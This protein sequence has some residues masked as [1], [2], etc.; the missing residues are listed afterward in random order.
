MADVAT[1][2]LRAEDLGK[3]RV[4]TRSRILLLVEAAI[5]AHVGVLIVAG[6]YYA[7]F[8]TTWFMHNWWHSLVPNGAIR[9]N[10]RDVGEGVLGA[11]LAKAVLWDHFTKSHQKS[12]RIFDWLHEK[13]HIPTVPASL[14]ATV[15]LAGGAF[16][17]LSWVF[18]HVFT[19]HVATNAPAGSW[20]HRTETLWNSNWDKKV[21]AFVCAFVGSRPM[22]DV[23]DDIQGY[24]AARRNALK[25]KPHLWEPV[26][27]RNRFAYLSDHPAE[28]RSYP[29]SLNII[30]ALV[31]IAGVAAASSGYYVLT[32][33]A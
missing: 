12:G 8:E 26:T 14:L 33:V 17:G 32:Y 1:A 23:F 21:L 30:V 27:F 7:L 31:V 2:P 28:V 19:L 6:L 16:I 5:L 13:L 25:R 22:H 4:H 29:T 24:F 10:I 11:F 18:D 15:V 9:H 3:Y 20:W